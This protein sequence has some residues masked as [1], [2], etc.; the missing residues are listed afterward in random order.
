MFQLIEDICKI[1]DRQW[2][3]PRFSFN[4]DKAA[5]LLIEESLELIG[6]IDPRNRAREIVSISNM[7][8]E[9][10]DEDSQVDSLDALLDTI[11]IAVGEL[12]KLGL[13]PHQIVDALQIVHNANLAKIGQKD[14][15]GKVCKPEGFTGP[16]KELQEQIVNKLE[17]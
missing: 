8:A 1:N 17:R 4:V 3:N 11:Y 7:S 10:N 13:K 9:H 15:E 6:D 5:A 16:E 12:H 14:S 2:N